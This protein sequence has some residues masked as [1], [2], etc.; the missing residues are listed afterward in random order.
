MLLK[1][2]R[3]MEKWLKFEFL[4]LNKNLVNRQIPI[5]DLLKMETPMTMDMMTV[6]T[7]M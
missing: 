1:N 7:V 4:D 5:A 2:E 3:A 6:I